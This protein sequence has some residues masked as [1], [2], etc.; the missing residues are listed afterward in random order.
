MLTDADGRYE[1]RDLPAGA[2]SINAT[3]I[4]FV[5]WAYGQ[6]QVS[7]P[8]RPLTLADGQAADNID[9]SLPRG[10]VITGRVTDDFG[11]PVQNVRVML[12]RQQ[13]RRAE[14]TLVPFGGSATTND[15]GEYRL[16]GLAPG[17]YYVSAVPAPQGQ[18][19]GPAAPAALEGPE[20]QNGYA[21]TF[22]P[23]TPVAASAQKLT[24]GL[25]QTLSEIN[26]VLL[27]ARTATVSGMAV[28]SQ[29]RPIT[30]SFV[31]LIPRGGAN[32]L[33]SPGGPI[34]PDGT[35]SVPNVPPGE[36]ALRANVPG[37]DRPQIVPGQPPLL[38]E[39]AIAFVS[40]NGDDV[41]GVRLAPLAQVH[42]TGRVVF[43]DQSAARSLKASA[44]RVATL[45]ETVGDAGIGIG[46]G[47]SQLPVSDDFTFD[48]KTTPGQMSIRGIAQ[49]W[50]VK[51]IRANSLDITD[52]GLDVGSQGVSGVE[53]EMTNRLQEISGAVTDANGKAVTEYAVVIF[54]Q[55]RARWV[56]SFNRYGATGRPDGEGRFKV[57]TLP[58]GEYYAIALDRSDAIEGQ[59]PEFLEGLT[60]VATPFSL[61]AGDTRTLELKLFIVQ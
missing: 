35:F 48:M 8:G 9:I 47:G 25:A 36:Y 16:F 6:T 34:R 21:P 27:T 40:V 53:I 1:F 32:G 51:A 50:Q 45:A 41:P 15:I 59:D 49:G 54:A 38:P 58:A 46:S 55:D 42:I 61:A 17:Q 11:D 30:G 7:R 5:G 56:A 60:R 28:D 57:T 23:G 18:V 3:K 44:V 43:D 31:T 29:G 10:A 39:F 52:T 14:R 12:L 33:G 26:M 24:V 19:F 22:Y 20:A 2:Y 4:G 37:V 13:F